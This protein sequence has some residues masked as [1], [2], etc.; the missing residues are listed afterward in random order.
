MSLVLGVAFLAA[1]ITT[2]LTIDT[3]QSFSPWLAVVLVLIYGAA[4]H[5][6]FEIGSGSAVPT[7][8]VLVP[9]LFLLPLG[10]VPLCVAAGLLCGAVLDHLHGGAALDRATAAVPIGAMHAF[11]PVLVLA[12]TGAHEPRLDDVPIYV[13]ALAAQFAFDFTASCGREW[14]V[15]GISPR[16]LFRYMAWV[17]AVD[18]ALAAIG[19]SIALAAYESPAGVLLVLPLLALIANFARERELRIGHALNLSTAYRGTAFLL[20]DV[21]EA[22]DTYTG[23]HSR[24]VVELSVAVADELGLDQDQRQRVELAALLHDVGKIRIPNEII[25][26]PGKLNATEWAI[27]ETHTIEGERMLQNVGGLLADVGHIVRSCHERW[28]GAGYPDGL[29]GNAIPLEARIVCACDAFHAMTS[30]RAYRPARS[31]EE[32]LAEL[33]ACAGTQFDPRVV[34]SLESV[35]SFASPLPT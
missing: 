7:E 16:R 29:L 9:M 1:A 19:L 31:E 12:A 8:L 33:R 13:A 21:I 10:A 26:K 28:D 20:G 17:Y 23:S 15:L 35:A 18:A 14:F 25:N 34:E 32:A 24:E 11:G 27:I 4:S 3:G 5:V 22:D 30:A 6:E 2:A